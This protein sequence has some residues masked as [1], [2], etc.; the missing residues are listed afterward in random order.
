[1]PA[2]RR[3]RITIGVAVLVVAGGLFALVRAGSNDPTATAMPPPS[4][5]EVASATPS[6]KPRAPR[7]EP[8]RVKLAK[9]EGQSLRS[10]N[11]FGR[12][13]DNRPKAAKKAAKKATGALQRYLNAAFVNEKS[14]FTAKP[15]KRL[16][17][18]KAFDQLPRRQRK[19]LGLK[20]PA[21][22][23]A[24]TR[25]AR[26]VATVLHLG[27]RV[28]GVTLEYTA[29]MKIIRKGVGRPLHQTG[30]MVFVRGPQGW[31]ADSIDVRLTLP[32]RQKRSK[33]KAKP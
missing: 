22:D 16:L 11:L 20:G 33:K 2:T 14:R 7:P 31:R 13:P 9:V 26:A 3:S 19:A 30:T 8:F 24:R 27:D 6:P 17:T 32:D 25:K 29:S 4:P 1:M 18:T 10:S 28:H 5:T 15:I 23:G 12:G 21:Y